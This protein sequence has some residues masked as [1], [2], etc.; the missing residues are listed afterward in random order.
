M[1]FFAMSPSPSGTI[2]GLT[3]DLAETTPWSWSHCQKVW[4]SGGGSAVAETEMGFFAKWMESVGLVEKEEKGLRVVEEE[5]KVE[6]GDE[7]VKSEGAILS[8][9]MDEIRCGGGFYSLW[10][11]IKLCPTFSHEIPN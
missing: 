7:R 11:W 3:G 1:S 8:A 9:A 6:E 10:F 4:S 2:P 5:R